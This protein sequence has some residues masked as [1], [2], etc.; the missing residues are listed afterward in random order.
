MVVVDAVVP[1][2]GAVLPGVDPDVC[3]QVGMGVVDPGVDDG[4]D[5]V[6]APSRRA[7]GLRCID[8]GVD[9]TWNGFD[10]LA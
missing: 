4:D 8:V 6:L 3:R 10:D 5:H 9:D 2:A 7:P 1:T